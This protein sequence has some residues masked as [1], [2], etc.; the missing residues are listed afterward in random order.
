MRRGP[1]G[2]GVLHRRE[3]GMRIGTGR[4]RTQSRIVVCASCV[5]EAPARGPRPG[6]IRGVHGAR[7]ETHA[8][9]R[10]AAGARRGARM[11]RMCMCMLHKE[12]SST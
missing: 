6:S 7:R 10:G 2:C 9:A 4:S 1:G 5:P 11:H 12:N 3:N 8:P